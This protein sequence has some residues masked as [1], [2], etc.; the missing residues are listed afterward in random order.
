MENQ[1]NVGVGLWIGNRGLS[2]LQFETNKNTFW[3]PGYG[4]PPEKC[5][6]GDWPARL[7][8]MRQ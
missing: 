5:G 6:A 2:E 3:V 7:L 1:S 8:G 4:T